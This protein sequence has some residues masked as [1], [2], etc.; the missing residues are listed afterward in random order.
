VKPLARLRL[1]PSLG[2]CALGLGLASCVAT[3]A[4]VER[5]EQRVVQLEKASAVVLSQAQ[6]ATQRLEALAKDSDQAV[7]D[8]REATARANARQADFDKGVKQLRG[9]LEQ[10]MHRL[11]A[12]EQASRQGA[13][14]TA[15]VKAKLAQLIV[16]LRDRAGIAILAMPSELPTEPAGFVNMA[17]KALVEGEVRT[18]VAVSNECIK[19][20]PGTETAGQ[21]GLVLARVAEQELRYADAMKIL[22]AVHDTLGGR[23]LPVVGQALLQ[24]GHLLELEGK[25]ARAGEVYKFLRGELAKLPAAKNAKELLTTLPQRCKEGVNAQKS[26]AESAKEPADGKPAAEPKS[27]SKPE[28]KPEPKADPKQ[29]AKSDS[30]SESKSGA[31]DDHK[32]SHKRHKKSK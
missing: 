27:E 6:Q 15:E 24:I 10:A 20:F 4:Q 1:L 21:C 12:L 3:T 9:D 22:Q 29:D 7:T 11:D 31:K 8:L 28:A 13:A 14:H 32:A 5:V 16:D 17:E 19:R 2:A 23:P 30:K 26:A 25:C 18:A